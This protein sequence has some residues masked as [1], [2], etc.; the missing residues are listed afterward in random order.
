MWIISKSSN[1]T[2]ISRSSTARMN[3]PSPYDDSYVVKRL[4]ESKARAFQNW[5]S[6]MKFTPE[7]YH[8]MKWN[9]FQ[10]QN[11]NLFPELHDDW[12]V[13]ESLQE[14]KAFQD[15]N[16]MQGEENPSKIC[17]KPVSRQRLFR[18]NQD[19]LRRSAYLTV[20]SNSPCPWLHHNR[21]PWCHHFLH[22]KMMLIL[23]CLQLSINNQLAADSPQHQSPSPGQRAS[24]PVVEESPAL[25]IVYCSEKN[26]EEFER[27]NYSLP[28]HKTVGS[29]LRDVNAACASKHRLQLSTRVYTTR[30]LPWSTT[31]GRAACYHFELLAS[32]MFTR[33]TKTC[34]NC[35]AVSQDFTRAANTSFTPT[36]CY[37]HDIVCARRAIFLNEEHYTRQF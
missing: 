21:S 24:S 28:G 14:S 29:L 2:R 36:C 5:N 20:E 27:Q 22:L 35:V 15:W 9:S 7:L 31:V 18:T 11:C 19:W 25:P 32:R 23:H 10:N 26:M 12:I 1:I 13:L 30:T 34:L 16:F 4:Q 8:S 37:I 33:L 6:I 3:W 17:N